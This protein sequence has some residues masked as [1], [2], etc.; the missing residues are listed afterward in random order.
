MGD[1]EGDRISNLPSDITDNILKRLSMRDAVRTSILSRP[2]RYKWVTIPH[3]V[4]DEVFHS[5]VAGSFRTAS[6]IYQILLLHKGPILK[7]SLQI[8]DPAIQSRDIDDYLYFLSSHRIEELTLYFLPDNPISD[9]LFS[10]DHLRH[11]YLVGGVVKLPSTFKR[12]DRLVRFQLEDVDFAPVELKIFISK[13]PMLEYLTIKYNGVKICGDL[14]S[15]DAPNLKSFCFS[16]GLWAP[17]ISFENASLLDEVS[18]TALPMPNYFNNDQFLSMAVRDDYKNDLFKFFHPL[19]SITRVV[20][21]CCF[22]DFLGKRGVPQKLPHDLYRLRILKLLLSFSS[23]S[24]VSSAACLIRSS[25]NL[26]TL[27]IHFITIHLIEPHIWSITQ[28]L[29][30]Q[31]E[32]E[33]RLSRLECV[34]IKGIS[35]SEPE[36]EFLKLLLSAA[37]ALRV[38]EIRSRFKYAGRQEES[39]IMNELLSFHRAS[40]QVEIVFR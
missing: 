29:K 15:I 19:C 26:Q 14:E 12:F 23:I 27:E 13:C 10:F 37:T 9:Y 34:R 24:E 39:H 36:M 38:L 32:S 25:P 4:F 30:T 3:L 21:S 40:P 8:Y 17:I 2:W 7:F 1:C 22:L 28:F 33:F 18:L 11:L 16:A 5:K 6:L 31:S 20:F 35:G